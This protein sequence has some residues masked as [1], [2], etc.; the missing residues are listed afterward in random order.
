MRVCAS[1]DPRLVGRVGTVTRAYGD[2]SY[3]ALEVCFGRAEVELLWFYQLEAVAHAVP[4]VQR[5][6]RTTY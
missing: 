4:E 3:R 5:S 6:C 2:P 1:E